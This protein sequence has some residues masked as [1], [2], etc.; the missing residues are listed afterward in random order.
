MN[1]K[2]LM[3]KKIQKKEEFF[4]G[5]ELEVKNILPA[6]MLEVLEMPRAPREST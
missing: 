1:R 3:A 6:E 4:H 2:T 5:T